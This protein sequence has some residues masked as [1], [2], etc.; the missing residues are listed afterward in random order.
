MGAA[1]ELVPFLDELIEVMKIAAA[2]ATIPLVLMIPWFRRPAT[3]SGWRRLVALGTLAICS[4]LYAVGTGSCVLGGFIQG[5][6]LCS[7]RRRG[8]TWDPVA[9][10]Y[11]IQT[12]WSLPFVLAALFAVL[13]VLSLLPGRVTGWQRFVFLATAGRRGAWREAAPPALPHD[14]VA[15]KALAE[16]RAR[17]ERETDPA[18]KAEWVAAEATVHKL[19][20]EEARF[21]H[22]LQEAKMRIDEYNRG[23][24]SLAWM[25]AVVSPVLSLGFLFPVILGALTQETISFGG[26][27][28]RSRVVSLE[29]EPALFWFTMAASLT[30]SILMARL[31]IGCVR[32]LR[33]Y[34]AF[35]RHDP[36]NQGVLLEIGRIVG[37]PR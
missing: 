13:S 20:E 19:K 7:F 26:R 2:L 11:A 16:L 6:A 14:P 17:I 9:D 28:S 15:E 25:A 33:S 37:G 18:R 32:V 31:A 22:E 12:V 23:F 30:L 36:E 8:A 24:K 1:M 35:D 29:G 3:L 10:F 4:L 27:Y 5:T 21:A 34:R